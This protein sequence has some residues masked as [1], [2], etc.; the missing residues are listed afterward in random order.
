[1]ALWPMAAWRWLG[2]PL[3][4]LAALTGRT[5]LR[6]GT[7]VR[8]M[9]IVWLLSVLMGVGLIGQEHW[10]VRVGNLVVKSTL[11]IWA[12]SLLTH[13][14][15]LPELIAALRRLGLSPVWTDSLAFWSRY[16]AVLAEEWRRM[17]LARRART[18]TR[19]RR[20]QFRA[21]AGGLGL[22]FVRAY[23]RAEQVHQAM[24][25]RG[26]RGGVSQTPA[27]AT[28]VPAPRR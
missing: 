19:D 4:V 1:M 9:G 14:T 27:A 8:R 18:M 17:Q 25:A 20:L 23:E 28:T 22:L 6:L 13:T 24:L 7:L 10:F 2:I 16:Y 21:L 26:Y 11:S 5:G 3:V 15:P 12:F